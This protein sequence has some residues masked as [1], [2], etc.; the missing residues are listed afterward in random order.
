M[1][2]FTNVVIVA[3]LCLVILAGLGLVVLE[4][5]HHWADAEHE[6]EAMKWAVGIAGMLFPALA[7]QMG[8]IKGALDEAA[9]VVPILGAIRERAGRRKTDPVVGVPAVAVVDPAQPAKTDDESD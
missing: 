4:F 3:T 5:R 2:R 7:L 9:E 8:S 6:F 1:K